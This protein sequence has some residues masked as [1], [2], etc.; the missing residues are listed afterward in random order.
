MTY[1]VLSGML[2]LYTT[3]THWLLH[4]TRTCHFV[5][6]CSDMQCMLTFSYLFCC[7]AVFVQV[8]L[9]FFFPVSH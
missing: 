1:N 6:C 8:Y 7:F 3:T 2:S 4:T 9:L 5:V